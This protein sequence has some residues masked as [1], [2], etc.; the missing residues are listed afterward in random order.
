MDKIKHKKTCEEACEWIARLSS[1]TASAQSHEQFSAWLKAHDDNRRCYDEMERLWLD[2]G[3]VKYYSDEQPLPNEQF[4]PAE[5]TQ[6]QQQLAMIS[7]SSA[8]DKTR[9]EQ[10]QKSRKGKL[11]GPAAVASILAVG[12]LVVGILGLAFNY[13]GNGYFGNDHLSDKAMTPTAYRTMVGQQT[14]ITLPDNSTVLL[15]TNTRLS[16]NYSAESRGIVLESGEA[17]FEVSKDPSRPFIVN[18][19][20]GTVKAIGTAFNIQVGMQ[21]TA[22]TVTEGTILVAERNNS[23]ARPDTTFATEQQQVT[24]NPTSGLDKV[25]LTDLRS[26][27]A[28]KDLEFIAEDA[29]LAEVVAQLNRYSPKKIKIGD[30]SIAYLPISGVLRLDQPLTTLQGIEATLNLSSKHRDNLILLYRQAI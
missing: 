20:G 15:N 17:H 19:P 26:T 14:R 10:R 25:K 8:N 13:Q 5:D 16:V 18:V 28:W 27:M 3:C 30:P 21:E 4:L 12:I 24:I 7:A 9:E 22:I 6:V 2:L 11:G 1:D 23:A 29:S